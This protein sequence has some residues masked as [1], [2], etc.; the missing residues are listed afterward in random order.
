[1]NRKFSI[2]DFGSF[3]ERQERLNTQVN[4]NFK[5]MNQNQEKAARMLDRHETLFE[6]VSAIERTLNGFQQL[7]LNLNQP[8]QV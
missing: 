6:R 3:I 1:M 5:L 7:I 2:Q 8:N 4:N